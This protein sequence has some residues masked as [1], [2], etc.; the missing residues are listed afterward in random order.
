MSGDGQRCDG[1]CGQCTQCASQRREVQTDQAQQA[2]LAQLRVALA[3]VL[4]PVVLEA[5]LVVLAARPLDS[6]P[7]ITLIAHQEEQA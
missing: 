6:W 2:A 5:V 1:K 7:D 3:P 4:N